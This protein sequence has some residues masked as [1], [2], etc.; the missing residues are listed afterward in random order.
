[1]LSAASWLF[2]A[3]LN[4]QVHGVVQKPGSVTAIN[5]APNSRARIV[6]SPAVLALCRVG[7]MVDL[8]ANKAEEALE[9][10]KVREG[11]SM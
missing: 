8:A 6:C 9:L 1:M 2:S 7:Q 4:F 10:D 5:T 11:V 3:R